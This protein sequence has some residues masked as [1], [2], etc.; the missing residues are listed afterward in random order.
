[1]K[2]SEAT[3]SKRN[4]QTNTDARYQQKQ[5]RNEYDDRQ[6]RARCHARPPCFFSCV[7][8]SVVLL[9]AWGA[10][11]VDRR[12]RSSPMTEKS[13]HGT[14]K[15]RGSREGRRNA[16]QQREQ[17]QE[18]IKRGRSSTKQ[19]ANQGDDSLFFNKHESRFSHATRDD[20]KFTRGAL[21]ETAT[22]NERRTRD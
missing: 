15:R 11:N 7:A 19:L 18:E 2:A 1:M 5:Q 9:R 8:V 21:A 17:R 6:T 13:D 10:T 3:V 14:D 20:H 12:S 16:T 4:K 22:L